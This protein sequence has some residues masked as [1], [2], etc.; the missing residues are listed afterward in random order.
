M[1]Q[2][3]KVS[4]VSCK[5]YEYE[6]V[7]NAILKN[8]EQ[9]GGLSNYITKDDV[10]LLK[11][12]LLMKKRPEEATTTHPVY[13]RALS[14]ILHDFGVKVIIGDSPG[15][16]FSEKLLKSMYKYTGYEEAS[17]LSGATLNY[18][19]NSF[20]NKCENALYLKS[21]TMTDMLNDCTKVI[22]VSKLKTHGMMTFTGAVKNMFGTIPGVKKAEYHF[23]MKTHDEF[24]D[25][26]IDICLSANP[27]LSFMDGIVGMEGEGP[28]GGNPREI[29]VSIA[30]T[31][32]Y[33]LDKVA[34]N[35]IGLDFKKVPTIRQSVKRG[36]IT[37]DLTDID[38]IGENV[39]SFHIDN[40]EIPETKLIGYSGRI[41]KGFER[42]LNKNIQP[43]PVFDYEKCVGCEICKDS[44]PAK[45]IKMVDKKPVVD[46]ED[47]IR[48]FCC[49]ELCPKVAVSVKRPALLKLFIKS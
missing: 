21:L 9:I 2:K 12:N 31:S 13:V 3:C 28:S 39:E 40:Y 25:C 16:P 15:G 18:N 34:C 10:V 17:E 37:D 41:P 8:I 4:L 5:D 36:F 48:C 45:V 7:K 23:N 27:V 24:A 44:C 35:I 33:H 1:D 29:G 42:F 49:Q 26:L 32:P 38:I 19:V 30:S 20:N 6:N 22:S 14:Q 47:C 43:K 46:L 11:V